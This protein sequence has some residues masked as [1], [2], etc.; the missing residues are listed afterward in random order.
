MLVK[1][2]RYGRSRCTVAKLANDSVLHQNVRHFQMGKADIYRNGTASTAVT[3]LRRPKMASGS[4]IEVL[5]TLAQIPAQRAGRHVFGPGCLA[6]N[7]ESSRCRV[8]R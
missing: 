3:T 5:D 2:Y 7:P 6:D 1:L 4:A 8:Q